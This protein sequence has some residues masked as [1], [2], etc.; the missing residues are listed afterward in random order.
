MPLFFKIRMTFTVL[1]LSIERFF[2]N[3]SLFFSFFFLFFSIQVMIKWKGI[4]YNNESNQKES[5]Q[6]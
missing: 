3:S 5:K 4:P 2:E 6:S 1:L